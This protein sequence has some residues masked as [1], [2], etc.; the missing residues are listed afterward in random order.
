[1][2][3]GLG[4]GALCNSRGELIGVSYLSM[5]D[6]ARSGLAVPIELFADH[7]DELLAHGR[8]TTAPA[9][10]WIGLLSYTLREHVVIAGVM[11]GGPGDKAGLKPGDVVLAVDGREVNERRALYDALCA[12]KPGEQI[13]IK[14]FRNNQVHDFAVPGITIE[15]YFG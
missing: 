7:R 5:P 3:S 11:P 4:G 15:D 10:I 8:R 1:M 9:R 6:I 2:N 13:Q 12:H 14:V